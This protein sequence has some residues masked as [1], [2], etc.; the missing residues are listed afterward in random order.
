MAKLQK[1]SIAEGDEIKQILTQFWGYSEFRPLQEEIIR[2]VLQ[3]KDTLALMPTGGGK[4][5]TFQVPSL[6]M[7]GICLVVT[8]LIALM[9]DQVEQLNRRK[10]KA[11]ALHSGMGRHE[12]DI[13]L[14]NCRYG[15]YKFLYVSPERL[16]TE[17]FITR[18]SGMN[19]N[20]IAVD[21]AHC[22][23]QW[24]Y[25]FRPSYLEIS[26][27]R[28]LLPG[29][30]V[31]A[32]T[33]TA[34]PE[35]CTD[36]QQQLLFREPHLLGMSFDRENLTYLVRRTGDKTRE[37][38]RL[39]VK[40][41][42]SG[43]VYVRSRRKCHEL[44]GILREEGVTA[45]YYHAG[46]KH[47][48][49]DQRQQEWT[50]GSYRVMVATN[51]FGMGIDKP[52]V[53]FV[54]HMDLPD[55]PE[56]YFQEAG[57]AGR[58]GKPAYAILL[59][60]ETDGAVV[61][62][63]IEQNFPP[64]PKIREIYTAL[65]N[66]LQVPVGS[67]KG[68]QYDFEMGEFLHRYRLNAMLVHSA[69]EVLTREGYL[70]LTDTFQNPSRIFF[71]VGRDDLYG[72]QVKHEEFDGF[73]KLLLRSYSGLFSDYVKIDETHLSKRS[74]I[75]R[76]KVYH[77]LKTLSSRQIIHYIPRK[78]VPVI[79]FLEERL[80]PKNLLISP[81]KY[82][83]RKERYEK[84]IREMLRYAASEQICR[85]QFLLSYFGQFDTPR[86]GRCDVCRAPNT[87][88]P[89]DPRLDEIRNRITGIMAGGDRGLDQLVEE[90]G[91]DPD[92]V[93]EVL[94]WMIDRDWIERKKDLT[95]HWK[96]SQD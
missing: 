34:T 58:D 59:Y 81:K 40:M 63:R 66:F 79:T 93:L 46:L 85:N 22:I 21:E 8:P 49:R 64:I 33:A 74:G 94:E 38:V 18:I 61:R 82:Q 87:P 53:R 62:R 47:E 84:R 78:E 20:L 39:V 1:K 23:S 55:G 14:E 56:A 3:K 91:G 36:I 25:D 68:Q 27:L 35:V 5:L 17:I 92:Q 42:G 69:L 50:G 70:A 7:E 19:V 90:T 29:V 65:G 76:E 86:C 77:Y 95:L 72:F 26:H 16:G 57:R 37:L 54:L 9:K 89:P 6:A 60:S 45:D 73:I 51:A 15:D 10:I 12:I 41:K 88:H 44:A 4:S 43:I 32:L 67:G 80:D 11:A 2:S 31:L 30:P 52:D 28:K 24:G 48:V 71:R 13:T 96:G 83:F 75:P